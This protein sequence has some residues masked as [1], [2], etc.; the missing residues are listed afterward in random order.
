VHV[1]TH[2]ATH[3]YLVVN[4]GQVGALCHGLVMSG[5]PAENLQ[6]VAA[7]LFDQVA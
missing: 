3:S 7:G 2:V 5:C 4:G 1:P 6:E